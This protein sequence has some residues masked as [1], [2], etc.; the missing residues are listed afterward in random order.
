MQQPSPIRARTATRAAL[1]PLRNADPLETRRSVISIKFQKTFLLL[2]L[3]AA[4]ALRAGAAEPAPKHRLLL[5]EYGKGPN[6]M[7]ELDEDGKLVQSCVDNPESAAAFFAIDPQHTRCP[8]RQIP[9]L[10]DRVRQGHILTKKLG[11]VDQ[12]ESAVC[13]LRVHGPA[14]RRCRKVKG[15]ENDV[16][17]HDL[18]RSQ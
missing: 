2:A 16:V 11:A 8:G 5:F 15:S 12:E 14:Y 17:S 4:G 6:R 18:P 1:L 10:G 9:D 3:L 7:L 13:R